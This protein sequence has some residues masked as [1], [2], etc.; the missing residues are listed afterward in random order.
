M[1]GRGGGGG[2]GSYAL[3][4]SAGSRIFAI[5][6]IRADERGR[7]QIAPGEKATGRRP[8]ARQRDRR[9]T[10]IKR[11]PSILAGGRG[12]RGEGRGI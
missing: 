5:C 11:Y 10:W 6:I 2:G 7:K 12:A 8:A 1:G 4:E 9:A 3:S